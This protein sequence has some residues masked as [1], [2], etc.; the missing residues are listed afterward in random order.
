MSA[1]LYRLNV[2]AEPNKPNCICKLCL[3]EHA[4][5]CLILIFFKLKKIAKRSLYF[6]S[7]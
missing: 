3:Y 4:T 1:C 6:F 2:T 5:K 7:R